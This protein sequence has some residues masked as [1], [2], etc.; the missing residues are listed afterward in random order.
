MAAHLHLELLKEADCERPKEGHDHQAAEPSL[1]GIAGILKAS[2]IAYDLR[3][4]VRELLPLV[5]G[6]AVVLQR[7]RHRLPVLLAV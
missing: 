3:C 7:G 6:H 5:L 2:V 4:L 1:A